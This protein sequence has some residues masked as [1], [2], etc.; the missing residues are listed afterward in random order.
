[1]IVYLSAHLL[2]HRFQRKTLTTIST[3]NAYKTT[4]KLNIKEHWRTKTYKSKII[5]V[6]VSFTT[7]IN[8][9]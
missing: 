7:K 2:M 1:M 9:S 3:Y 8:S 4:I 6:S 5:K